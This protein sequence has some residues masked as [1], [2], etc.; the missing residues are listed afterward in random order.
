METLLEKRQDGDEDRRTLEADLQAAHNR[1]ASMMA[2]TA[3]KKLVPYGASPGGWMAFISMRTNVPREGREPKFSSDYENLNI[4]VGSQYSPKDGTYNV[5]FRVET[6]SVKNPE[7]ASMWRTAA[8]A[9][10][11]VGSA[12]LKAFGKVSKMTKTSNGIAVFGVDADAESARRLVKALP[13]IATKVAK[14]VIKVVS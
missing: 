5:Y 6:F 7:A 4:S 9:A 8:V 13:G 3:G 2:A 11:K 10:N 14:A 12:Q 1:A